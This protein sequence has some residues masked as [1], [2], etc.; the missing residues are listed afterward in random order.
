MK[1]Q[2]RN[3]GL[4]AGRATSNRFAK[5]ST[6]S[7]KINRKY[8]AKRHAKIAASVAA[9]AAPQRPVAQPKWVNERLANKPDALAAAAYETLEGRQ[10]MSA[11]VHVASGILM[12]D[13]D[14]N[15]ASR[16]IVRLT[17]EGQEVTAYLNGQGQNF[18]LK[19][20][21]GI[22]MT[23]SDQADYMRV[24]HRIT[25]P[26]TLNGGAGDDTIIGG[27]GND[28]INGG[29]GND[30]LEGG[31]GND[32]LNGGAG[33]DTLIGNSGSDYLNGGTG[34]DVIKAEAGNDSLVGGTGN[35]KLFG[36]SGDDT[37]DGSAGNDTIVAHGRHNRIVRG[38]HTKVHA[39]KKNIIVSA[40]NVSS[41]L[42]NV[43]VVGPAAPGT[44]P[45]P[46]VGGG[47]DNSGS[48]S[49]S[50][51]DNS[52]GTQNTGG[53]TQD[54]G[55]GTQNNGGGTQDNGGGTQ[56]NGGGTQDN[57][58]G[59]QNKGGGTQDN[60]GGNNGGQN[61]GGGTQDNGGGTQ[62]NGG[63]TVQNDGT[64][65]NIQFIEASGMAGHAV[66][67]NALNSTLGAGDALDATYT[68]DFGDPGS[69]F[70]TLV[71][72][73]AGHVYDNAGTYTVTLTVTDKNGAT[74][75]ATGTV[76][77]AQDTRR[78]IYVDQNGSDANSG[79][80]PDAAVA[81]IARVQQLLGPN[82]EVLFHNGQTFNVSDSLT[83]SNSNVTISS[84][85]D[86]AP[87]VLNKVDG[88][89]S[90]II[91]TA[92]NASDV[93]VENISLNSIY[94]VAKYG[95]KQVP[96]RGIFVAGDNFT[97]RNCQFDNVDDAITTAARPTGVI[98]QDNYFGM[99]IR[100]NCIWGEG[101]DHVYIG[102]TFTNSLQEHLIRCSDSGVTRLLVEDNSFSRPDNNKGSLELRTAQWFYVRGNRIVGG[103]LRM[104]LPNG[105]LPP[106]DQVAWG[107]VENNETFKIFINFR[108]G[109]SHIAFR[110]NVIHYDDGL[111]INIETKYSAV[112]TPTQDLRIDHNTFISTSAKAS[113][114]Q[115][116]GAAENISVTNNLVVAPNL[117][118]AG[119]EAGAIYIAGT[120]LSS[121]SEISN[122]I[123]PVVDPSSK[124]S[125][126]NY[127]YPSFNKFGAGDFVSNDAWANN[128]QVHN[129]QYDNVDLS[130][131]VYSITLNGVTAGALPTIFNSN[132]YTVAVKAAA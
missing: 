107:V 110:D 63:G 125:G 15:T 132:D 58:G 124:Q 37:I 51:S 73:N 117:K 99:S 14:P 84:Y 93:V 79:A 9:A 60:G 18:D 81:S 116:D 122:N 80:T 75:T 118:W 10:L 114:L 22:Q 64:T 34:N 47:N 52:G 119:T 2:T 16:M 83:I 44:T 8:A 86:G 121:F 56:N 74:S 98:V 4:T 30:L 3:S 13:A 131:D 39:S 5:F 123:W 94:T 17:H 6:T 50:G 88:G 35:D 45:T 70:N 129:E 48:S 130:G 65:A 87:A 71:G 115:L 36:G 38:A 96:A 68:W 20:L 82:T 111:A 19:D 21:K 41:G 59:T 40:G 61:T 24:D 62:D 33:N 66:H 12:V 54:N 95:P 109:A 26:T 77:I 23:G 7:G 57:G 69:R 128:P 76:T 85:G 127:M 97:V 1:H 43:P 90:S 49:N 100:S 78:T 106:Q 28:N 92:A 126:D 104:G 27:S 29:A 53:G 42:S 11:S 91:M 113:F 67:V 72:W 25:L 120:D 31:A 103:T 32:A 112:T 108:P 89:G 105:T 102:N 46:T 55:G 101:T